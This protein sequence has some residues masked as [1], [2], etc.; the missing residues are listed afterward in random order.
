LKS[1]QIDTYGGPEVMV[2][3]EL[4]IPEPGPGEL[5]V[6]V[7]HAGINVMDI[8]TRQGKYARSRTYAVS[9]PCT[10]GMEGA[11]RVVS[12]G[13][14]VDAYAAGDRVAW[15]IVWGSYAEFAV[16]PAWRAVKV[17]AQLSL[18]MAAASVFHGYTAH[19]LAN[20]V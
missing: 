11:G 9:V 16:V 2:R 10:L 3:R 6:K 18:E 20:D 1:I 17:P 7:S 4:P 15:C 5:L 19:Y 14:G 8:H 13:P 12:V